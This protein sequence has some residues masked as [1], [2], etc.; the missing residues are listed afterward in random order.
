MRAPHETSVWGLHR[1]DQNISVDASLGNGQV[2]PVSAPCTQGSA[3]SQ[4]I[5]YLFFNG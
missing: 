1:L 5:A 4:R 2:I 3:P